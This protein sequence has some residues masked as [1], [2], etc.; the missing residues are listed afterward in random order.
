VADDRTRE[1][2]ALIADTS[3]S[4]MRVARKLDR[5]LSERG[6]TKTIVSDNGTTDTELPGNGILRWAD[7]HNV[8]WHYIAPGKPMQNA[9]AENF[10]G[11]L[12][13]CRASSSSGRDNL[14]VAQFL[15]SRDWCLA[16][17]CPDWR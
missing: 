17:R 10:I 16:I 3:I 2:V 5:L 1:C 12:D 6:K 7:D 14:D 8:A 13:G 15:S 4:R 9:F 11:R